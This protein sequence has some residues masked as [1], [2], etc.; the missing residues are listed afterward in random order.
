MAFNP[1]NLWP[2]LCYGYLLCV[3]G[4][5]RTPGQG[6]DLA[7]NLASLFF[8]VNRSQEAMAYKGRRSIGRP[9]S[10]QRIQKDSEGSVPDDPDSR[11]E[12][13]KEH[14]TIDDIE[15]I[16]GE[17][18]KF[19]DEIEMMSENHDESMLT[20]F[21]ICFTIIAFFSFFQCQKTPFLDL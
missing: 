11:D 12:E 5:E 4:C 13:L 1:A 19:D 17:D 20:S 6:V 21:S 18:I 7:R 8:A 9:K 16:D 2:S 10:Y 3:S 15:D 14:E